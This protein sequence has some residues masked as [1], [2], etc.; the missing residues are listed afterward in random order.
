M[1]HLSPCNSCFREQSDSANKQLRTDKCSRVRL[2]RSVASGGN[3]HSCFAVG[4]GPGDFS[5]SFSAG[6]A[7]FQIQK[8]K[9]K[10]HKV[11]PMFILLFIGE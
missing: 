8:A 3:D 4:Q 6:F 1:W 2:L 5:G 7:L 10:M 9:M 11:I